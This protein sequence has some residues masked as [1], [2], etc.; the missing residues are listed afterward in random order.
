MGTDNNHPPGIAKLLGRLA[1][2]GVGAV[3]NRFELLTLEWQE[4]RAKLAEFLVW[5]AVFVFMSVMAVVLLTATIIY[6][7]PQS[8]RVYVAG[9]FTALYFAGAIAAW[10]TVKK[11]LKQEPFAE[12]LDQARRD[13]EWL[14]SFD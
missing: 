10:F 6:L 5:C 11:L 4:E 12:S 1:R 9:G 8:S 13:R 3:E 2:T 14:K 7:C